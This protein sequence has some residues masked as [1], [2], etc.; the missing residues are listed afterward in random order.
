MAR[1][2]NLSKIAME[3][4]PLLLFVFVVLLDPRTETLERRPSNGVKGKAS[5][6]FVVVLAFA[7]S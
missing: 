5:L 3:A 1:S 4:F 2:K 6:S 7:C